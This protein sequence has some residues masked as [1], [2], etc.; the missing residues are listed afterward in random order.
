MWGYRGQLHIL[1]I[2][3]CFFYDV[4]EFKEA[5]DSKPKEMD[6]RDPIRKLLNLLEIKK[7]SNNRREAK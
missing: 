7:K 5:I 2:F 3:S 1:C 6:I 4:Q